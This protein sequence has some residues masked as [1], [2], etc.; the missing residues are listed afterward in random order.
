M[1][2][3]LLIIAKPTKSEIQFTQMVSTNPSVASI[4]H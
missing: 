3:D 2:I 4:H 1:Q